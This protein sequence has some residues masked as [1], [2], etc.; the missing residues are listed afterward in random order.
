[1]CAED[2]VV[3][4]RGRGPPNFRYTLVDKINGQRPKGAI[5]S[6]T[7]CVQLLRTQALSSPHCSVDVAR[8]DQFDQPCIQATPL[9]HYDA[10]AHAGTV[11]S[12]ATAA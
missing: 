11:R 2:I 3:Y 5:E 6:T 10:A 8:G 1:M 4:G 7:R 9:Q 12:H